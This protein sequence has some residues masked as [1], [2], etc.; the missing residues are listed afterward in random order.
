MIILNNH[1]K[2]ILFYLNKSNRKV[3]M[4]NISRRINVT[5]VSLCKKVHIFEKEGLITSKKDGVKRIISLT[6]KGKK[7]TELLYKLDRLLK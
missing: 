3:C 1:T 2:E 5:Y 6:Q 4:W 7:V